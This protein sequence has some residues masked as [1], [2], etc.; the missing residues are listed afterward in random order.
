[1]T[2]VKV[3]RVDATPHVMTLEDASA[4]KVSK[5]MGKGVKVGMSI[6]GPSVR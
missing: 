2:N 4:I 6:T 1:M 3:S 5:A